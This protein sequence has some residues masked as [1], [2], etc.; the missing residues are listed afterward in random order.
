MTSQIDAD[1]PPTA[2]CRPTAASRSHCTST[3]WQYSLLKYYTPPPHLP[4]FPRVDM[5]STS[6]FML[7]RSSISPLSVC[8]S[9]CLSQ[10]HNWYYLYLLAIWPHQSRCHDTASSPAA[11]IKIPTDPCCWCE[12]R[13]WVKVD[14]FILYLLQKSHQNSSLKFILRMGLGGKKRQLSCCIT[15]KICD[16]LD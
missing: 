3:A 15:K 14:N 16:E 9:V 13:S 5:N 7:R 6:S 1:R 11:A 8:P 10:S 4:L 2:F 12:T